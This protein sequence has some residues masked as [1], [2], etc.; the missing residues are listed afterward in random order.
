MW[1]ERALNCQFGSC[2]DRLLILS[3]SV[4]SQKLKFVDCRVPLGGRGVLPHVALPGCAA[5][6]RY[7][8]QRI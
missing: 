4:A 1:P 3:T 8:F 2:S 5:Q 6:I 7:G